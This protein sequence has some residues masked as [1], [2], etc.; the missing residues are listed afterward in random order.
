LAL[1]AA[2]SLACKEDPNTH[3]IFT[4]VVT[5]VPDAAMP[6]TDSGTT[7]FDGPRGDGKTAGCGMDPGQPNAMYTQYQITA[8]G[9]VRTYFVRLPSNYDQTV[10]YRVAYLAPGCGGNSYS[11]V[12]MLNRA[13]ME[14]AILV[15]MLPIPDLPYN[16][17]FEETIN[18]IEY[19]FFD[20]LHQKIESQFCVDTE[21]QFYAGF[22]TGARLGYMLGCAFP[23]VLRA[24]ATDQGGLPPL[25]TCKNHPM[26][27]FF[28]ADTMEMGNPYQQ[29]VAAANRLAMQNGCTGNFNN[30]TPFD[31]M[32]MAPAYPTTVCVKYTGCP[33][34]YPIVFCTTMGQGH[35][36]Y[37]DKFWSD[38]A[39]WNFFK[40]F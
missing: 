8:A 12:F 13:S 25:P 5:S 15:A 10:P 11:E 4:A 16:G 26:S 23:D 2:L 39:F 21:R 36:M 32:T 37:E 34:D 33:A 31:P 19:P 27:G 38:Q 9:H 22:S 7:S 29:N 17:C 14:N 3:S 35:I 18:S 28:I 6:P 1:P 20:A 30:A 40:Q 24:T